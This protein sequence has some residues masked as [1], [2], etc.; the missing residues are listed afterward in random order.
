MADEVKL[1]VTNR[2]ITTLLNDM[3]RNHRSTE[4][5]GANSAVFFRSAIGFGIDKALETADKYGWMAIELTSASSTRP[6]TTAEMA[7]EGQKQLAQLCFARRDDKQP[8]RA[9]YANIYDD[10]SIDVV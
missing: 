2:I 8:S 1:T 9:L 6:L 5:Y 7:K 3:V 10:L 4:A